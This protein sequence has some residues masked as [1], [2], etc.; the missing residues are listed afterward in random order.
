MSK[1]KMF[2]DELGTSKSKKFEDELRLSFFLY[3]L[4]FYCGNPSTKSAFTQVISVKAELMLT[5]ADSL[6]MQNEHF[7]FSYLAHALSILLGY[8]GL[9][10]LFFCGI[11]V[12]HHAWHSLTD[13]GKLSG[14]TMSDSIA[15]VST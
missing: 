7:C 6:L 11:T 9:I 8:A 4:C 5:T 15:H 13:E 14:K 10:T 3:I 2:E 12:S 1:S